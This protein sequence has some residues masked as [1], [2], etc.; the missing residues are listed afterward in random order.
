LELAVEVRQ[1]P[2]RSGA[3]GRSPAVPSAIWTARRRRTR[4]RR[5]RRRRTRALL[6][7]RDPHLAG[8]EK[9]HMKHGYPTHP[10]TNHQAYRQHIMKLSS[11]IMKLHQ[12]TIEHH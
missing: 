1:C 2:L 12:N 10:S 5:R 6:K 11:S 4:T 8:G 3:P 9:R 7:S